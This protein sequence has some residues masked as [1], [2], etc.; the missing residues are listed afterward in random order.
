MA[1][2][3]AQN[4]ALIREVD[5]AVRQ[6]DL[7]TFWKRYGRLVVGLILAGLAAFGGWLLWQ[8]HQH[9]QAEKASDAFNRLLVAA[10]GNAIEPAE[11]AAVKASGSQGYKSAARLVEAAVAVRKNDRKGAVAIYAAVAADG[12]APQPYR[13]LALV[14]QTALEFEQLRPDAIIARMKPLA[15]AGNPWF[16]SAGEM[17]AIAQIKAGRTVDAGATLAALTRDPAVPETIKLRAGQLAGTFGVDATPG[18]VARPST[19]E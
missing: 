8:N 15:V 1:L 9:S 18:A 3:P 13:D 7:L 19:S 16:G 4:E 6:D 2:T 14:R 17:L 10:N 11:L 5:D 12:N